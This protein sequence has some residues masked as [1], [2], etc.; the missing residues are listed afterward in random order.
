MKKLVT[1]ALLIASI[2]VVTVIPA[3]AASEDKVNDKRIKISPSKLSKEKNKCTNTKITGNI[4]ETFSGLMLKAGEHFKIAA[5]GSICYA[6]S[7]DCMGPEGFGKENKWKLHARI[8][9]GKPFP[10]GASYEVESVNKPGELI[11]MLP[12]GLNIEKS[13][14]GKLYKDNK[15]EFYVFAGK[16]GINMPKI[17]HSK[18]LVSKHKEAFSISGE[19]KHSNRPQDHVIDIFMNN[20]DTPAKNSIEIDAKGNWEAIDIPIEYNRNYVYIESR[21]IK[22]P[23][24]I[25][26]RTG[27]ITVLYTY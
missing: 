23:E 20:R 3:V 25:T 18:P 12:E 11:F 14:R 26:D 7:F 16:V 22:N 8:G 6:S 19:Y 21:D 15:G 24:Y 17:E 27:P 5:R 9:N 4:F 2:V 1:V 13:N 10:V